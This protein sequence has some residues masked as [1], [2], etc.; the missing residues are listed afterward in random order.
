MLVSPT[1]YD[2][3]KHYELNYREV[4]VHPILVLCLQSEIHV[5]IYISVNRL[6]NRTFKDVV[7]N[8]LPA[9]HV[10]ASSGGYIGV[11]Y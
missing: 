8:R 11:S 7:C 2:Q 1:L 3:P 4:L 10:Y 9:R 5:Y 6:G